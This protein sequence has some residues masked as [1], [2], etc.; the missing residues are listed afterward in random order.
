MWRMA[1]KYWNSYGRIAF[2]GNNYPDQLSISKQELEIVR[3]FMMC[4]VVGG[5]SFPLDSGASVINNN[6]MMSGMILKFSELSK[7]SEGVCIHFIADIMP[8]CQI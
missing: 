6:D 2:I 7:R 1:A 5:R 8:R 4:H 3:P